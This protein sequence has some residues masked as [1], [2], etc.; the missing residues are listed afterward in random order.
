MHLVPDCPLGEVGS[1]G[2]PLDKP[3]WFELDGELEPGE[4]GRQRVEGDHA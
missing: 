4:A 3:V 2:Q 1:P